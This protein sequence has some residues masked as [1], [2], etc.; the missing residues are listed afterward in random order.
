MISSSAMS[1]KSRATQ[2]LWVGNAVACAILALFGGVVSF[3]VS[4][5]D[6]QL[7]ALAVRAGAAFAVTGVVLT[8][9]SLW[10]ARSTADS[11]RQVSRSKLPK[12]CG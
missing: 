5:Y 4:G 8:V 6:A 7:S 12:R 9:F 11:T 2:I 10:K 1:L 3:E